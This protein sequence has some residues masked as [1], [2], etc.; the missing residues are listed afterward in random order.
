MLFFGR[1]LKR[2]T[3]GEGEKDM[4]EWKNKDVIVGLIVIIILGLIALFLLIRREMKSFSIQEHG[5]IQ[6][7]VTQVYEEVI[8]REEEIFL[9]EEVSVK[10][11][12]NAEE[13]TLIEENIFPVSDVISVQN[14]TKKPN[15]TNSGGNSIQNHPLY[16]V[17]GKE[18]H[19]SATLTERKKDDGQLKELYEYWEDYKLNAVGDLIRLERFQEMSE[20]LKGRNQFYY[21]PLHRKAGVN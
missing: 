7:E 17:L 16:S 21:S 5:S 9:K 4:K 12:S 11:E 10:E 14:I 13:E 15:K 6:E 2:T 3:Y 8:D 20:E 1:I 19:T 18:N